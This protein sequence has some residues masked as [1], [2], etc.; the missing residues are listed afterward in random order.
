MPNNIHT[1]T[2]Q[3]L[4]KMAVNAGCVCSFLCRGADGKEVLCDNWN[5]AEIV[6]FTS[7]HNSAWRMA[8]VHMVE[9][10]IWVKATYNPER[11]FKY[12]SSFSHWAIEA[13]SL[14]GLANKG[15]TMYQTAAAAMKSS[16]RELP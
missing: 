9:R 2:I 15:A 6:L 4:E 14:Q 1:R 16:L 5:K 10:G 12:V 11:P 7:L 3:T 13:T 8:E